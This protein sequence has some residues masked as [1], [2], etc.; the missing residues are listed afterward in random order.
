MQKNEP[1]IMK[2]KCGASHTIFILK[3]CVIA[4]CITRNF[5]RKILLG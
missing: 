2:N 5:L 4:S 1:D 3:P